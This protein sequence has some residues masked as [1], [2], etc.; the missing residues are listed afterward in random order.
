MSSQET[1]CITSSL[2]D[3]RQDSVDIP[4]NPSP[5]KFIVH[6]DMASAQLFP[7]KDTEDY[8]R[9]HPEFTT[10]DYTAVMEIAAVGGGEEQPFR[11]RLEIEEFPQT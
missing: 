6:T 7:S 4:S 11:R 2:P 8:R 1:F 3:P 5:P 9:H 10:L